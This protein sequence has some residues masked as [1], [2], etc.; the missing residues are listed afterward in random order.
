M[1]VGERDG[2]G[3]LLAPQARERDFLAL[4]ENVAQ[5]RVENFAALPYRP[6][7]GLGDVAPRAVS[8][9]SPIPPSPRGGEICGTSPGRG[10]AEGQR[11]ATTWRYFC[12]LV[13]CGG[14]ACEAAPHPSPS[15][16]G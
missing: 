4:P 12:C 15:G 5:H 16:R 2:G 13:D 7:V 8:V 3:T 11:R 6:R 9:S 10:A 14:T 1:M